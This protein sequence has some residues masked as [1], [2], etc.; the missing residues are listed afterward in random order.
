MSASLP[1][2]I[3]TS[4]SPW[5]I[6]LAASPIAM[7][8]DAHATEYVSTGP[9]TPKRIATCAAG[10]LGMKAGIVSGGTRPLSWPA[11]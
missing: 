8:A 10:A 9:W 11:R 1:P 6:A 3:A 5:R 4:T 7:A 2:A